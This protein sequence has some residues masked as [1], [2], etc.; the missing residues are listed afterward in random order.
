[1]NKRFL[2]IAIA[3]SLAAPLTVMAADGAEVYGIAHVTVDKISVDDGSANSEGWFVTSRNSRLGVK[4]SEDLGGGMKAVYKMEF[5][6]AM[7]SGGGFSGRN[8]YVGIS[9]GMGTLLLG[10][11]DTPTKLVQGKFDVF[12]DTIADMA[13]TFNATTGTGQAKVAG[14]IRA[15]NT[16]LYFSPKMGGMQMTA[17]LIPGEGSTTGPAC[18]ATSP[19]DGIADGSSI[20]FTYEAGALYAGL[21]LDN[22]DIMADTMRLVVT[23]NMDALTAGF[24]YNTRSDSAFATADLANDEKAMGLS[25]KFAMGSN[26]IKAQYIQVTD[27]AGVSGAD[28]NN[29]TVGY[30][31]NLSARTTVYGLVNMYSPD[32]VGGGASEDET[33]LSAGIS[34]S[35]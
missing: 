31:M 25:V 16:I 27:F 21:G 29:I 28:G 24:L 6:V 11:H 13:S 14:D 30:D 10:R 7:D 33:A 1:M 17:M 12:N 32:T 34:H 3:A 20:G 18:T 9:G 35:F 2:A 19:C 15:D 8:Q 22:G 4:G 26:A 23:Y 5:G